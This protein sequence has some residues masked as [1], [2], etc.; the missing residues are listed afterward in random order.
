MTQLMY[1]FVQP[2]LDAIRYDSQPLGPVIK[3][4][5]GLVQSVMNHSMELVSTLYQLHGMV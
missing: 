3:L 5:H 4:F 2:G 1:V